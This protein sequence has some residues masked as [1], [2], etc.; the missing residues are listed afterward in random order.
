MPPPRARIYRCA[1]C[2]RTSQGLKVGENCRGCGAPITDDP[3]AH[4]KAALLRNLSL[5]SAIIGLPDGPPARVVDWGLIRPPVAPPPPPRT[6]DPNWI[7]QHKPPRRDWADR[8]IRRLTPPHR[9]EQ[10]GA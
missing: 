9:D 6:S 3:E 2:G 8:L 10:E 4:Y 1:Y 7:E 5:P